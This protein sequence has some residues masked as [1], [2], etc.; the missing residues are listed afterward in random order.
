MKMTKIP[1]FTHHMGPG[2]HLYSS[3]YNHAFIEIVYNTKVQRQ[4]YCFKV[5]IIGYVFG[6]FYV[7][8]CQSSTILLYFWN[9]NIDY[10][11]I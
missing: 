11:N 7:K 10:L 5:N 9:Q 4:T 8:C 3:L 6:L 2:I 1:V